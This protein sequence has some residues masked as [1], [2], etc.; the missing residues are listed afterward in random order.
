MHSLC[1]Y[2]CARMHLHHKLLE[3]FYLNNIMV[4]CEVKSV[5][6]ICASVLINYYW[7]HFFICDLIELFSAPA[8]FYFALQ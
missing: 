2:V 1:L 5:S 8:D 7:V 3:R 6:D 4:C